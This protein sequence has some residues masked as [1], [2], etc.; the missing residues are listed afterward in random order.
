MFLLNL[1]TTIPILKIFR[2]VEVLVSNFAISINWKSIWIF[3]PGRPHMNRAAQL[4]LLGHC[5]KRPEATVYALQR[6]RQATAA[7]ATSAWSV[8]ATELPPGCRPGPTFS[9]PTCVGTRLGLILPQVGKRNTARHSL[10]SHVPLLVAPPRSAVR[11]AA[12]VSPTVAAR[13]Q[14]SEV[15]PKLFPDRVWSSPSSC[16]TTRSRTVESYDVTP[17]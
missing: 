10:L 12:L 3:K 13:V 2:G 7:T 6:A 17:F 5:P 4:V 1:S 16:A 9:H 11:N 8:I 14:P 15:L